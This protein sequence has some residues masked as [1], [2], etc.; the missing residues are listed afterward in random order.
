MKTDLSAATLL[1]GVLCISATPAKAFFQPTRE[2]AAKTEVGTY[3]RLMGDDNITAAM[4]TPFN[5]YRLP[6]PYGQYPLVLRPL[7]LHATNR[8]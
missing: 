2:I 3:A 7:V 8:E 5:G 4:G 6:P 1:V